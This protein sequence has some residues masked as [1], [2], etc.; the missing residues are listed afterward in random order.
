MTRTF[1][2][3]KT[4]PPAV[5]NL[6]GPKEVVDWQGVRSRCRADSMSISLAWLSQAPPHCWM[7]R[8]RGGGPRSRRHAARTRE[9]AAERCV[10]PGRSGPRSLPRMR[11]ATWNVNSVKA[12]EGRVGQWLEEHRPDVLCLQELKTTDEAFPS[13]MVAEAGYAAAVHGQKTYNGVAILSP[14]EIA[15]VVRGMGDGDP[16]ARFIQVKV[17][18]ITILSAYFPNGRSVGSEAF[19]YKLEWMRRLRT[20]L[21][22]NLSPSDPVALAGDFNV[23]PDSGDVANP[24]RWARSVLCDPQARGALEVIRSWGFVD[25]FRKHH[26]DGGV[27]SWWDYRQLAF[28][29]NDGLR[30]DHVFATPVLADRSTGAYIDR[31]QRKGPKSDKPSDH[32]PVVVDFDWP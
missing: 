15:D 32:A 25:V 11:I 14:H 12:R 21:D 13:P 28:P 5:K 26:P 30:I 27:Y 1:Q 31:D 18:G 8:N 2:E 24:D 23:A 4:R 9:H 16:Q 17:R 19:E 20:W 29:R 22:E 7:R 6:D 10:L 3:G